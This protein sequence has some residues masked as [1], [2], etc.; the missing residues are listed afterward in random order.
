MLKIFLAYSMAKNLCLDE[1]E[2]A[3]YFLFGSSFSL[4]SIIS[5]EFTGFDSYQAKFTCQLNIWKKKYCNFVI[6]LKNCSYNHVSMAS[7]YYGI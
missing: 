5:K 1:V 3:F 4:N 7:R 6:H 2:D